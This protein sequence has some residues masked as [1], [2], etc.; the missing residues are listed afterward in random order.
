[1]TKSAYILSLIICIVC[2]SMTSTFERVFAEAAHDVAETP[3]EPD[4][5]PQSIA[6]RIRTRRFPSIFEAWNPAENLR[7]DPP[8][9]AIP[10]STIETPAATLSRHDL[11]WTGVGALGLRLA[12]NQQYAILSPR[13]TPESVAVARRN[14]ASLLALNPYMLVLAEVH[15]Y[16]AQPNFLPPDSPWWL[17]G[18]P[19][20]GNGGTRLDFANPAFQDKAAALCGALVETGVFDG[21]MLDWWNDEAQA[22]D[23][24]SL[25]RKMREAI[26]EKAIL[27]GNV[28]GS[29]PTHTAPYLN[30]MYMEGFGSVLLSDWRQAA[31]NLRWG[32]ANLREPAITA[33]EWWWSTGRGQYPLMREVTALA[34]VFSDGYVLFSDPALPTP[35][36]LHD[37]YHFWTKTLGRPAGRLADP[38]RPN[39]DGAYSRRFE[40]GEVVFN[41]PSNRP[42]VVR[43]HQPRHSAATGSTGQ[44]FTVAPGDGDLFLA[45][46]RDER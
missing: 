23:R 46:E 2:A 13:F 14:R 6:R 8:V 5:G 7:N 33:L 45:T 28:N 31:R 42:V 24:L 10:L 3:D 38:D 12:G 35:D 40:N 18:A 29:L 17:G 22:A 30:G 25:I 21:C 4:D 41:P 1:M 32:E 36:H 11:Y 19:V 34:L 9:S 27:L 15:Y 37:W 26:G 44:S 39:L 43:F 20:P 16:S